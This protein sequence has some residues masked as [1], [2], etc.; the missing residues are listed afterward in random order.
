MSTGGS[1]RSIDFLALDRTPVVIVPTAVNQVIIMMTAGAITRRFAPSPPL[2]NSRGTSSCI[3]DSHT[4]QIIQTLSSP[5][6][7]P[8]FPVTNW[9][10]PGTIAENRTATGPL[11]SESDAS[12]SNESERAALS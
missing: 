8:F 10:K 12:G 5:I 1:G 11:A 2:I 7:S 6:P 9:P 4:T 3:T